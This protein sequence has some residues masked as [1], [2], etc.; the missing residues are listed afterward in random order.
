MSLE[1]FGELTV[2][3]YAVIVTFI[4]PFHVGAVQHFGLDEPVQNYISGGR[5]DTSIGQESFQP[6]GTSVPSSHL[7]F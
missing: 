6:I 1:I 5:Y 4:G 7:G 2:T 3:S